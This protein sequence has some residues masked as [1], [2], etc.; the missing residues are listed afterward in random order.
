MGRQA[1]RLSSMIMLWSFL[2]LLLLGIFPS[3]AYGQDAP[4]STPDVA[5][6]Y[7][8]FDIKNASA[9]YIIAIDTSLSMAPTYG[10]VKEALGSLTQSLKAGDTISVISF[11]NAPKL[12]YQGKVGKSAKQITAA[13]PPAPNPNG[14]K[15]DIGAAI[16]S[17]QRQIKA[18]KSD[19]QLVFFLTDG[20]D[21]PP[22]SSPFKKDP[23]ANWS[24]LKDQAGQL[25]NKVIKIHGVGLNANTDI[26]LLER[27]FP[28]SSQITLSPAELK[29]YFVRLKDNIREERLKIQ[30]T[31]ELKNG[32]VIISPVGGNDWGRIDSKGKLTRLYRITSTYRH[33]AVGIE[34]G[35]P[36]LISVSSRGGNK[37]D[38]GRFNLRLA[39]K[40][41]FQLRPG[42]S[43]IVKL[44]L[45][46]PVLPSVMK[47]G[48]SSDAYDGRVDFGLLARMEPGGGLAALGLEPGANI[49]RN[50]QDFSFY[51]LVGQPI[52]SVAALLV[53]ALLV[54]GVLTKFAILP[55][56]RAAH[57]SVSRPPLSGR[58]AFAAA[59]PNANLPPSATLSGLGKH[60]IIGS[61]GTIALTGGL[62]AD[63]HAELFTGWVKGK[64]AIYIRKL[65]GEVRV[66]A[67]S[68][69][70]GQIIFDEFELKRG[71]I[72]E[73]GG[74]KFQWL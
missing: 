25:R 22:D 68:R 8:I 53:A 74:Y 55:I 12:I 14:Q 40:G 2:S 5:E 71:N 69:E 26:S 17:V 3:K 15:T 60:A 36:R 47:I 4:A 38:S 34:T 1:R 21:E 57:R 72:I 30:L 61:A 42:G 63:R 31:R 43:R 48:Q 67:S 41:Q 6:L 9:H 45:A 49:A 62:V 32:R 56:G 16:E 13:L 18:S 59:P 58:L 65:E 20:R 73:L 70:A 37:I 33:L 52:T 28:G 10:Q 44:E 66:A 11:D 39:G 24:R 19:L 46:A 51:H 50:R 54:L 27:I 64:P 29:N 35:K 7:R 23:N